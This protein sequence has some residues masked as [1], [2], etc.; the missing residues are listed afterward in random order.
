MEDSEER[1]RLKELARS[2]KPE[3]FGIIIRTAARNVPAEWL[4]DE[5]KEL[6]EKWEMILKQQAG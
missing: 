2:L 3:G 1:K 5:I 4:R 6:T